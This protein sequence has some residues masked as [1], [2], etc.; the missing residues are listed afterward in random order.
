MASIGQ[1]NNT[2]IKN[3]EASEA[4]AVYALLGAVIVFENV[5]IENARSTS[6]GSLIYVIEANLF[7][8]N[9]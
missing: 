6:Q 8:R 4:G 2:A 3:V 9:S 1:F 7:I 5:S